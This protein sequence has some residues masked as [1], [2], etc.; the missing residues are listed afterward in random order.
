M[1]LPSG[2]SQASGRSP[3]GC[4]PRGRENIALCTPEELQA[5]G[6][7]GFAQDPPELLM[8]TPPATGFT[9][10]AVRSHTR[11]SL[12]GQQGSE[13][14]LGMCLLELGYKRCC[15][16]CLGRSPS[17]I[18]CSSE[19]HCH[20][21]RGPIERATRRGHVSELEG[22][23]WPGRALRRWQ[24]TETLRQNHPAEPL[25]DSVPSYPI[26]EYTFG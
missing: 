10:C 26:G 17:R 7:T 14:L 24:L 25:P 9:P 1:G 12:R 23:S 2:S 18:A 19:T 16:S 22:R 4:V 5:Q 15:I 8:T 21:V 11:V 20:R 6:G 13:E 3:S